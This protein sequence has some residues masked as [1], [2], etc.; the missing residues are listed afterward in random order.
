MISKISS[1]QTNKP[2]TSFGSTVH[3]RLKN[4]EIMVAT[5]K[6]FITY[7]NENKQLQLLAN[8]IR[9]GNI[10]LKNLDL[11][12]LN[13]GKK[14]TMSP[15][16]DK[17][18]AIITILDEARDEGRIISNDKNSPE[19]LKQSFDNLRGLLHE[20]MYEFVKREKAHEAW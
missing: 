9:K 11:F 20:K 16:T 8:K 19:Y 10:T 15:E 5:P 17:S 12:E 2:Q 13:N 18:P 7:R 4:P 3:F 6:N 14:L 1:V